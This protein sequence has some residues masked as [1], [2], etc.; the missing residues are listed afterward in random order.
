MEIGSKFVTFGKNGKIKTIIKHAYRDTSEDV[1]VENSHTSWKICSIINIFLFSRKIIP[2][3]SP[4]RKYKLENFFV[5]VM[6]NTR[7]EK[8]EKKYHSENFV[9]ARHEKAFDCILAL[10]FRVLLSETCLK[11]F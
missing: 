2:K 3:D 11:S 1:L 7:T 6:R 9:E 8:S 4:S 5:V 10:D